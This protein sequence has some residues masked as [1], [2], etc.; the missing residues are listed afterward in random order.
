MPKKRFRW[1]EHANMKEFARVRP[2]ERV[3][4]GRAT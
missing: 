2:S 3:S 1:Y 4:R